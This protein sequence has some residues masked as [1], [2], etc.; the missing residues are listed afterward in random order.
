M[1]VK[2]AKPKVVC[3][4]SAISR[5]P[6]SKLFTAAALTV[7]GITACSKNEIFLPK[8]ET[9]YYDERM[10]NLRPF[11]L[12]DSLGV[13]LGVLDGDLGQSIKYASFDRQVIEIDSD[14]GKEIYLGFEKADK[15]FIH[16]TLSMH[17]EIIKDN[18]G[19]AS[20]PLKIYNN[21]G[22]LTIKNAETDEKLY[23]L[24]RRSDHSWDM[25]NEDGKVVA[26]WSNYDPKTYLVQSDMV[27]KLY[28]S[29]GYVEPRK[30]IFFDVSVA[31]Y[32]DAG[33]VDIQV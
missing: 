17:M 2:W 23:E 21:R 9:H 8:E 22:L 32:E 12:M 6:I 33:G 16:D 25:M 20:I 11:F 19:L 3:M 15:D 4:I 30:S 28:Q 27:E 26:H 10:N 14:D 1:C 29:N 24:R 5:S 7:A 31:D 13:D 18:K